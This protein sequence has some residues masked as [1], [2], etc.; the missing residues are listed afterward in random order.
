MKCPHCGYIEGWDAE[1]Q[2]AVKGEY[3]RFYRPSNCIIMER[4]CDFR[5]DELRLNGCPKCKKLFM[6]EGG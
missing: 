6:T 4:D 1:T 2:K 3:R 5:M